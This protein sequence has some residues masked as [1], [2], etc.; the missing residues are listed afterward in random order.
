M[1]ALRMGLDVAVDT[2]REVASKYED[3]G[4]S[5]SG[6]GVG[7]PKIESG[8]YSTGRMQGFGRDGG[9]HHMEAPSD[10]TA[11]REREVE[12][13]ATGAPKVESGYYSTGKMRG[14]GSDD[15]RP[16]YP[17]P[18]SALDRQ[19]NGGGAERVEEGWTRSAGPEGGFIRSSAAGGGGG[20]GSGGGGGGAVRVPGG[21]AVPGAPRT[22]GGGGG[23]GHSGGGG[24]GYR[25]DDN[26]Y[27]GGGYRD[28][29]NGYRGGGYRDESRHAA[30]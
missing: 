12:R 21:Y 2:I 23:C 28:D 19:W 30:D 13:T 8:A 11:H 27:R 25:D 9:R 26:G 5:T 22:S 3:S 1:N 24:G 14:F 7:P 6:Y 4:P 17:K 15:V 18:G 16:N 10:S 20:G 29:E